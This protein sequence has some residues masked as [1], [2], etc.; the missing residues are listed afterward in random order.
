MDIKLKNRHKLAVFLIILIIFIPSVVMGG[1]YGSAFREMKSMESEEELAGNIAAACYLLYNTEGPRWTGDDT[2]GEIK[3]SLKTGAGAYAAIVNY[4]RFISLVDYYV[5]DKVGDEVCRKAADGG[6][7]E[8]SEGHMQTY[9]FNAKVEF[10]ESGFSQFT[11][12][13][14]NLPY[15]GGRMY[16]IIDG[17]SDTQVAYE[18]AESGAGSL[19]EPKE[20]TYYFGMSEE[21]LLEYLGD[22]GKI[23]G[24]YGMPVRVF[25]TFFFL[26]MAAALAAWYLPRIQTLHTG[27]EKIFR[28]PFLEI[29]GIVLIVSFAWGVGM[30]KGYP[31]HG[32]GTEPVWALLFAGIYWS[33]AC[34]GRAERKINAG[35]WK[36]YLR[37]NTFSYPAWTA[38]KKTGRKA[39]GKWRAWT[40]RLYQ[41]FNE[42]DLREKNNKLLLKL[43]LV[44]F[45]ILLMITCIW[46]AG[47]PLL[48]LY[49]A[50]LFFILRRYVN[51]LKEKYEVLLDTTNQMAQGRLDVEIDEDL[52]I[53]NPFKTEIEKIQEG[54]QKAVEKEVKSQRMKTEL[55]TNV[56]HDL[57]TPLTAIITY[58]NLLKEEKDEEKRRDYIDVL[59][60][61]SLR[62][63]VLIEDLFEISKAS[64]KNVTLDLVDVDVVNLFKQVRLEHQEKFEEKGLDFRCTYPDEK[65]VCKLDS[66][67]TYR[68]FENLLV[69]V[70]K[71]ALPH[72]RVYVTVEKKDGEA[73]LRI[74]NISAAELNFRDDE[75]TERFVRGDASRNTEGSGLGLAIVKSFT[76]VQ[77]GRFKVETEGDLFK[78][79]VAFPIETEK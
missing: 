12:S 26:A 13:G 42:I 11:V 43:V 78:A 56:S 8:L 16:E 9:P 69:N 22:E 6:S 46:F 60:K 3:E 58:V 40:D 25:F 63:K 53:F 38:A 34:L 19:A 55:I 35:D 62:L 31:A 61:K 28:I 72:T 14:G 41:S 47:I 45:A 59:D 2:A 4:N 50:V 73:V 36:T 29:P 51:D 15:A 44:N 67:K 49:F 66:Q 39:S 65:F 33:A 27:E 18:L 79:E 68:I 54:Y 5:V 75:I 17:F 77:K 32:Y 7:S 48:I 1:V 37:E 76:E 30:T 52:G 10:D 74:M 20:R 64:S 24:T 21:K 57:K 70:A 23:S 71:Y